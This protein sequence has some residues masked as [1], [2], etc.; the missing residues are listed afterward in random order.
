MC[1]KN[2]FCRRQYGTR[3]MFQLSADSGGGA[4]VNVSGQLCGSCIR[5]VNLRPVRRVADHF[6]GKLSPAIFPPNSTLFSD[7]STSGTRVP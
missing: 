4:S 7:L 5:A 1:T 6:L 2:V 3:D